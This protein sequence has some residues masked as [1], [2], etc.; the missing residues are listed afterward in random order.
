MSAPQL[1]T[2]MSSER[3]DQL[4]KHL[5]KTNVRRKKSKIMI[6]PLPNERQ[7]GWLFNPD[8][9]ACW[10]YIP[11]PPRRFIF[12]YITGVHH[13]IEERIRKP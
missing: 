11:G 8:N 5:Q 1:T 3:I 9:V 12:V 10:D 13:T 6:D 4:F 7:A 2:K